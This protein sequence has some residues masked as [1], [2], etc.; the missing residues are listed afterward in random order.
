MNNYPKTIPCPSCSGRGRL[1]ESMGSRATCGRCQ[2]Y[3]QI[4]ER[5]EAI[6]NN[7]SQISSFSESNSPRYNPNQRL[8]D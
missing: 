1:Q 4:S 6:G 3:G 8:T 2:G 5:G 7:Q